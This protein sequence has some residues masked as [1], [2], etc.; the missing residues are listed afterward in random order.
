MIFP[1]IL[2]TIECFSNKEMFVIHVSL[3]H[4]SK[5]ENFRFPFVRNIA[6]LGEENVQN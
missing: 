1:K 3:H 6:S 5:S 4:I 2:D